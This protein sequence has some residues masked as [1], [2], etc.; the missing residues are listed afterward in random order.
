MKKFT[1]P[2]FQVLSL[3]KNKKNGV[4]L[5][6]PVEYGF[7]V[8]IGNAIRRTLLSSTPGASI[9]GVKIAGCSHEFAT[10][11]GV[12]ENVLKIILN[13]K[14]II[15]K[16][17]LDT[18]SNSQVFELT[19]SSNQKSVLKAGDIKLPAGVEIINK[20]L[21]LMN[22]NKTAN[23]EMVLYATVSLGYKTFKENK[24]NCKKISDDI[25]SIDSNFSPIEKINFT[26][27]DTKIGKSNDL[28]KLILEVSTNGSIIAVDAVS[29]ASKIL[30][31]HLS[32]F[33]NLQFPLKNEKIFEEENI[34]EKNELSKSIEELGFSPRSQKCLKNEKIFTLTDLVEYTE[35]DIQQIRNL[36]KK[37]FLEIK[38]KLKELNLF[39]KI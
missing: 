37:S 10:I 12:T 30:I 11:P 5:I 14:D 6:E 27:G 9:F 32:L 25:I 33:L 35:N 1:K 24:V 19:L 7:A 38:E 21:V 18:Y 34:E 26:F 2:E 22:L 23:I 20:D 8:T 17:D 39:F 3:D 13:I 36:G 29:I 15:L 16:A 4:F 28:E 31:E